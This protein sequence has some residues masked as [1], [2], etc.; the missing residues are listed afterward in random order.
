MKSKFYLV[1]EH[2]IAINIKKLGIINVIHFFKTYIQCIKGKRN[3]INL[4]LPIY[5]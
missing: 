2:S 1:L 5:P 3:Y 4:H